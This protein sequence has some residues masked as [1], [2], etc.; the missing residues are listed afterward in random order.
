MPTRP[1]S[2]EPSEP[3][4]RLPIARVAV[5]T[6][7]RRVFDYQVPKAISARAVPGSRV[8]VPF[9]RRTVAGVVV[10]RRRSSPLDPVRLKAAKEVLDPE[11][12]FSPEMLA[13][14]QWVAD[15]YFCS[16]GEV[17][18]AALPSGLGARFEAGFRLR[19]AAQEALPEGLPPK[20]QALLAQPGFTAQAFLKVAGP[21][22]PGWL[23]NLSAPGGP[24]EPTPLFAGTRSR[25]QQEIWVSPGPQF[26]P[27]PKKYP[28]RQRETKAEHICRIVR[29]EGPVPM[30]RL[31]ALMAAPQPVVNKL[32]REKQLAVE[33][34]L[35]PQGLLGPPPEPQPFQDLNVHQAAAA[36]AVRAAL[37]KGT[38]QGFLLDGV[39]G[40]GKT[41]VYLHATRA[42]LALGKTVLLLVP[43][44]ALTAQIVER[45]RGR[46]GEQ[47][48]LLHSGMAEGER[49]RQW[50]RVLRG[51]APVVVGARSALFAPLPRL[52]LV[53]V[54][55]EHDPSYKQDET[56]RYHARDAALVRARSAGAVALLGSATPSLETLRNV[57]LGKLTRLAL[58]ERVENRPLPE[59]KL[60]S[61]KGAPRVPGL[62]LIT[63]ELEEALREVEQ[64]GE[65]ALLFLNRR[66]FASLVRC[67]VCAEAVVC[68][69]CSLTLVYHRGVEKLRCHHCDHNVPFPV[70]CPACGAGKDLPDPVAG[71]PS[72]GGRGAFLAWAGWQNSDAMNPNGKNPNSMSP[73]AKNPNAKNPIVKNAGDQQSDAKISNLPQT[74][75]PE[76]LM[77]VVGV[78]TERLEQELAMLFPKAGILRMDSDSLRRRGELERM[79]EAIR[80]G[81]PRFIVGT[82]VLAKGHDFPNISL[83]AAV[84]ADVALNL[85]DFR[86]AERAFHQL[87]QV[88]GRAG[89]GDRP[90]RV[91]IQTYSPGHHALRHV[92]AHDTA[93]FALEEMAARKA[94]GTPPFHHE[95]MVW[96]SSPLEGK[97]KA[98]AGALA[99]QLTRLALPPVKVMGA[100]EAPIRKLG[101]RFRWQV[102]LRADSAAPMRKLLAEVLDD[103]AWRLG[104]DERIVV[105][106]DPVQVL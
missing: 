106:V 17:L 59:V 70:V 86:A 49:F 56:P 1:L 73:G 91:L 12:L 16:W 9:G 27:P 40:S 4:E 58:P 53:V 88:A 33:R 41:E 99:R 28:N 75:P 25:E 39:T 63:R 45:F 66:G 5:E 38:Y 10:E 23:A 8:M 90:G 43:E 74:I 100:N 55:E 14:T 80:Q 81:R 97:A 48:A 62:F 60:I 103:P 61:L 94:A 42:A 57:E 104:G 85:P 22:G 64:R 71:N 84:L 31:Q 101:G 46:F 89:R 105:D 96:V 20:A 68:P 67:R 72:A 37:G 29:E 24:L 50:N 95:V 7:L 93:G 52:G 19:P 83:A 18:A 76:G 32:E 2:P 54:D 13:F 3:L 82:Q 51:E 35:K 30:A 21:L 77:E 69:N 6:P 79:V 78:G 47:V 102:L 44:I 34:R 36:E 65:Q 26:P 92:I 87:T 11:P 98:L 15:Y